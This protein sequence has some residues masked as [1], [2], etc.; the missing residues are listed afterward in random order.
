M[1]CF[2]V[3]VVPGQITYTALR[4]SSALDTAIMR[5]GCCLVPEIAPAVRRAAIRTCTYYICRLSVPASPRSEMVL[6]T[7]RRDQTLKDP[8]YI[9]CFTQHTLWLLTI[10]IISIYHIISSQRGLH[11]LAYLS[12]TLRTSLVSSLICHLRAHTT[13]NAAEPEFETTV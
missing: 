12:K 5:N 1:C 4:P 6:Q 10:H 8:R 11:L 9:K 3:P 7:V 13:S 2:Y